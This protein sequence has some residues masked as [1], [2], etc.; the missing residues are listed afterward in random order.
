[1]KT[2]ATLVAVCFAAFAGDAS[3]TGRQRFVQVQRVRQPF[4]Q[5]QV[6]RQ[7][8]VAPVVRQRV[9]QRVVVPQAFVAPVQL[10][11]APMHAVQQFRADGGCKQRQGFNAGGGCSALL[12]R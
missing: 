1:M 4:I 2:L 9:V 6:V 8:I 3:A 7:R 10:F 5:R 12:V 11:V